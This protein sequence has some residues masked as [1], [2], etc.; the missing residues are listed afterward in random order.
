MR[1]ED[2]PSIGDHLRETIKADFFLPKGI[3]LSTEVTRSI[4]IVAEFRPQAFRT[5][6]EIQLNRANGVVN[7]AADLQKISVNSAP[8]LLWSATGRLQ[9]IALAFL[10]KTF[11]RGV[12]KWIKQFT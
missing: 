10:L 8:A 7:S 9:S 1:I 11:G 6:W 5:W 3:R 12:E 2:A 4:R